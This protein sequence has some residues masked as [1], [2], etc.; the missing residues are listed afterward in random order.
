MDVRSMHQQINKIIVQIQFKKAF[1]EPRPIICRMLTESECF[2]PRD[3][4][5]VNLLY[6]D[7]T[8]D[9]IIWSRLRFEINDLE[10][11]PS[12]QNLEFR[13][14]IQ[15]SEFKILNPLSP[16]WDGGFREAI[17]IYMSQYGKENVRLPCGNEGIQG[18][19]LVG[20]NSDS[21]NIALVW[22]S[23]WARKC[24]YL[25]QKLKVFLSGCARGKIRNRRM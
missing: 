20:E 3:V 1:Q 17:T 19:I 8:F 24:V 6:I 5:M 13:S 10:L 16:F 21:Q 12:T 11:N 9:W 22:G 14:N 15:D 4:T 18:W 2:K 25:L 23:I 7:Y